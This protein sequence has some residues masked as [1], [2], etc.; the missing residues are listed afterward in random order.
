MASLPRAARTCS[1]LSCAIAL[2]VLLMCH[3]VY[4]MYLLG[5]GSLAEI[6]NGASVPN[7]KWLSDGIGDVDMTALNLTQFRSFLLN[8]EVRE[9]HGPAR[10]ASGQE[11]G[12]GK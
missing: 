9:C 7:W 10:V 1:S 11:S 4:S 8:L 12:N 2:R 5:E 6:V 3:A